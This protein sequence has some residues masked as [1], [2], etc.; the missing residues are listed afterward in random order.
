M[1]MLIVVSSD[2]LN[3]RGS[4]RS[5]R[6]DIS[7]MPIGI[8]TLAFTAC[9]AKVILDGFSRIVGVITGLERVNYTYPRYEG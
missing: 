1:T 6:W 2:P 5:R 7:A 8:N 3:G 9:T 4:P